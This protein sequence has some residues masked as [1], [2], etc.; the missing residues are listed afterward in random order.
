MDPN[1]KHTTEQRH[2]RQSHKQQRR[3]ERA[4]RERAEGRG[5]VRQRQSRWQYADDDEFHAEKAGRRRAQTRKASQSPPPIETITGLVVGTSRLQISV[6][7]IDTAPDPFAPPAKPLTVRLIPGRERPVVGDCVAFDGAQRLV[8]I[9]P[10]RTVLAR[11]DPQRAHVELVIAANV[12]V[13]VIVVAGAEPAFRPGLIDRALVALER[14]GV[15]PVIAINK[16]DL[17][18][19]ATRAA[20]EEHV[21]VYRELGLPVVWTSTTARAGLDELQALL[22][23]RTCVFV[24][25]SGVGK[26]SLLNRLD[27]ARARTVG[28]GRAFDGKGRHTTTA[29]E[30]AFLPGGTR[31]I[32]TPGVRSFGLGRVDDLLEAF[33]DLAEAARGCRFG[34]CGHAGEAGCALGEA[35]DP[36]VRRR[37]AI[38]TRLRASD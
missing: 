36:V 22:A 35:S 10:R 29:A 11:P 24:G 33:P 31:L 7:S 34:N 25:H 6:V 21:A 28:A 3:A 38:F 2:Q 15:A 13:G 23:G 4:A 37:F 1:D 8:A 12:D 19:A 16:A 27:P 14:G 17:V 18:D 9:E 5:H 32:D 26:S 20:I 30:L